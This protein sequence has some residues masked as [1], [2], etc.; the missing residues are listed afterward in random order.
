MRRSAR[1]LRLPSG[2]MF[3]PLPLIAIAS[4]VIL[5][6][7]LATLLLLESATPPAEA[8]VSLV[9]RSV[10]V[11]EATG[12]QQLPRFVRE[13]A[14]ADNWDG[15]YLLQWEGIEG[16]NASAG[17]HKSIVK[18]HPALELVP[19][20]T[21]GLHRLGIQARGLAGRVIFQVGVWIRAAPNTKIGLQAFDALNVTTGTST[22]DLTRGTVVSSTGAIRKSGVIA[23][24][25]HWYKPWLQMRSSNGWLVTYI[26]LLNSDGAATY[27][28]DGK[29]VVVFGGIEIMPTLEQ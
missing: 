3:K 29:Q 11:T 15:E 6:F 19:V 23:R 7:F 17:P 20:P 10:A 13:E 24:S 25:D 2:G 14:F 21:D 18:Y 8:P 22:Y 5:V 12:M 1:L 27:K 26:Q 9:P 28:G 16:L 4:T